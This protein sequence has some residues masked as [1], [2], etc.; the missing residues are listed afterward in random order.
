VSEIRQQTSQHL[1]RTLLERQGKHRVPGVPPGADSQF[2]VASHTKTFTAVLVMALR[3]E[4]KLTLDT[5]ENFVP[6]ST[7]PGLTIRRCSRTCPGCRES[8]SATS[9]RLWSSPTRRA[10]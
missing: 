5:L 3:D 7:H 8:R 9:G 6:E 4:G 1:R 10:W 2:L